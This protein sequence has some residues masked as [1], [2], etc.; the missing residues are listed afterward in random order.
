MDGVR[1]ANKEADANSEA[2]GEYDVDGDDDV[3]DKDMGYASEDYSEEEAAGARDAA[4]VKK[5]ADG[6]AIDS[7]TAVEKDDRTV[8]K[9]FKNRSVLNINSVSGV[10][11]EQTKT[12]G[13]SQNAAVLNTKAGRSGV[14]RLHLN[15]NQSRHKSPNAIDIGHRGHHARPC[16]TNGDCGASERTVVG[17]EEMAHDT[18]SASR[19]MTNGTILPPRRRLTNDATRQ[20]QADAQGMAGDLVRDQTGQQLETQIPPVERTLET[21]DPLPLHPATQIQMPELELQPGEVRGRGG[22]PIV[23]DRIF[24]SPQVEALVPK[25]N[26]NF[27]I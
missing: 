12:K 2:D 8:N 23:V 3:D 1:V 25:G 10:A 14:Q 24:W 20:R 26:Y 7:Q 5:T 11:V 4:L 15:F 9:I 19:T 13:L 18:E 27:C 17:P 21:M 6:D 16:A 22:V